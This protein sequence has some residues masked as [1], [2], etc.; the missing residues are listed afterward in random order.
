M[1]NVELI[2]DLKSRL[3]AVI[4]IT[5]QE[6]L[7]LN[8]TQLN[9]KTTPDKWSVLECLE[10]LNRYSRYYNPQLAKHLAQTPALKQPTAYA[11]A[12]LGKKVIQM[13]D[14]QNLKKSKTMSRYNPANSQLNKSVLE[15]FLQH[16]EELLRLLSQAQHVDIR[17]KK[18]P[19]EFFKLLHLQIGDA[20]LFVIYHTQRHL[21]QALRMKDAFVQ[22]EAVLQ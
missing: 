20:L 22:Q 15:E 1:N 13:I 4:R 6:I 9:W 21:N 8:A 10:H 14:P 3:Q 17:Q 11:S 19:V 12:W 2:Q 16:Q 18:I 7:P 5:R